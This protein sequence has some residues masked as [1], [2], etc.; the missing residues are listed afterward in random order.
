MRVLGAGLA[1]VLHPGDGGLAEEAVLV[2]HQVLVDTRSAHKHTQHHWSYDPAS[3]RH[4]WR[5]SSST[6]SHLLG[7]PF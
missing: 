6:T 3:A 2:V 4:W 7:A 1:V 5:H